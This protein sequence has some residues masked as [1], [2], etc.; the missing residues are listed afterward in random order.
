MVC[1]SQLKKNQFSNLIPWHVIVLLEELSL[2][3]FHLPLWH[4]GFAKV[5]TIWG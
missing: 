3:L 2:N 4:S 1:S 5:A